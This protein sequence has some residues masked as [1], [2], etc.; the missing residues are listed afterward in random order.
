MPCDE[1]VLLRAKKSLARESP[2]VLDCTENC[3]VKRAEKEAAKQRQE[4]EE[5]QQRVERRRVRN[6]G[7]KSKTAVSVAPVAGTNN[8]TSWKIEDK[9]MV[10]AIVIVLLFIVSLVVSRMF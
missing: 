3:R 10:V 8:D 1:V 4:Q 6:V 7:G 9:L 5:E 2:A